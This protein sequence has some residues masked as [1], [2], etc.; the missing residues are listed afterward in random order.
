MD[1]K[2]L[3]APA[4]EDAL[5]SKY[6]FCLKY[7]DEYENTVCTGP[8]KSDKDASKYIPRR[9]DLGGGYLGMRCTMCTDDIYAVNTEVCA[10]CPTPTYVLPDPIVG[11]HCVCSTHADPKR[12]VERR[13]ALRNKRLEAHNAAAR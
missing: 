5:H 8:H 12:E 10:L 13:M 6:G 7:E 3:A 4:P 11:K 1:V 9:V 2:L